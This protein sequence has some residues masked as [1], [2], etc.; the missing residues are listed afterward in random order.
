[1]SIAYI[2]SLVYIVQ[3]KME[4]LQTGLVSGVQDYL[5]FGAAVISSLSG[6][7]VELIP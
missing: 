7:W 5:L 4:V 1:M 6:F 3:V 2:N